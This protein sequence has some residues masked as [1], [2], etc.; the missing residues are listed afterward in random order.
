MVSSLLRAMPARLK[1]YGEAIT[2]ALE[3]KPTESA[4]LLVAHAKAF[5]AR[6]FV[7]RPEWRSGSFAEEA[8]IARAALGNTEVEN[9][10]L[11]EARRLEETGDVDTLL[12]DT[13]LT[14]NH[15]GIWVSRWAVPPDA[16]TPVTRDPE[17]LLRTLGRIGTR[18]SLIALAKF[19]RSPLKEVVGHQN[20]GRRS[21]RLSVMD[22]LKF[23]FPN[24]ADKLLGR[25]VES[26]ADYQAVED[27]CVREL[28]VSYEG[29]PRLKFLTTSPS[30]APMPIPD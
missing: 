11:E 15:W 1:K 2:R 26:D 13:Q 20:L 24:Q 17:E 8:R 14:T 23:P 28:G 16:R 27:F 19:M 18:L 4:F 10:F 12:T 6:T 22:A 30:P 25:Y 7:E 5:Q 3:A 9:E 21:I 29:M